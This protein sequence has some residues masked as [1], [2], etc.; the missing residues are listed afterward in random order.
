MAHNP[1]HTDEK[2]D[3][4]KLNIYKH[5]II[6]RFH[7][8][9]NLIW[10]KKI[11]NREGFAFMRGFP[12]TFFLMER[13]AIVVAL[14]QEKMGWFHKPQIHQVCFEAGLDKLIDWKVKI[15]IKNKIKTAYL[16][17]QPHGMLGEAE[18]QFLRMDPKIGYVMEDFLRN[19]KVKNPI[20]DT[21]I[22]R[23]D[24]IPQKWMN[25]RFALPK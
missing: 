11:N 1:D 3:P 18:I 14:F 8:Y 2:F 22:V 16:K 23:F 24:I 19:L 7:S 9:L 5:K 15:D 20:P 4:S 17:F 12:A 21:G 10:G 25:E 13:R 6:V